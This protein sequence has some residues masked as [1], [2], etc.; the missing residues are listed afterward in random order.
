MKS[1]LFIFKMAIFVLATIGTARA[2]IVQLSGASNLTAGDKVLTF[3]GTSLG[4]SIAAPA[5]FSAGG[6]TLT[7]TDKGNAFQIDKVGTNY[8]G[9]AFANGTDILYAQGFNGAAAPIV[10]AFAVPV[11][12]I[13]LNAEEFAFGNYTM[14]FTATVMALDGGISTAT[15]TASG[16]DPN[17]LSFLGLRTS[18]GAVITSLTIL[19]NAGNNIALGPITFQNSV[20]EPAPPTLLAAAWMG[21]TLLRRRGTRPRS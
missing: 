20:A 1:I 18:G 11:T 14:T 8:S 3:P 16:N 6:N 5:S 21:L 2:G 7:F 9:S 12:E 13:G 10:V 4:G 15:F 19:D 17:A